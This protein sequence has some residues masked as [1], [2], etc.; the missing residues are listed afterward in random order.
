[1]AKRGRP[2]KDEWVETTEA[3]N[4]EHARRVANKTAK[5]LGATQNPNRLRAKG[6]R[7]KLLAQAEIKVTADETLCL[8]HPD[9]GNGD[10]EAR[11]KIDN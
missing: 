3:A 4:I 1:M 2:P 7:R 11:R 8:L 5:R 9:A 6:I 10:P